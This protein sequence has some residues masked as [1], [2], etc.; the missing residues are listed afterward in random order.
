MVA[1]RTREEEQLATDVSIETLELGKRYTQILQDE[2]ITEI[3]HV[4]ARLEAEGDE[5][6]LSISGIGRKILSDIK[7]RLRAM[8]FELP[9]E[10]D[11]EQPEQA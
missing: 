10:I 5:G 8:G 2:G 6:I 7:R 3:G 1:S 4:L 11:E 9:F